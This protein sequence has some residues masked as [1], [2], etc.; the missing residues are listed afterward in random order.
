METVWVGRTKVGKLVAFCCCTLPVTAGFSGNS[1]WSGM[2]SGV[3][4]SRLVWRVRPETVLVDRSTLW[5]M[6]IFFAI[7]LASRSSSA[8][9]VIFLSNFQ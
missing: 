1:A 4:K 6:T 7:L 5:K 9:T 8:L 3:M 2:I